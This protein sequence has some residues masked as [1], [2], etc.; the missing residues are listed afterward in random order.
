MIMKRKKC[1]I[2]Y[3]GQE[4]GGAINRLVSIDVTD[5]NIKCIFL[6]SDLLA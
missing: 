5:I 6:E 2:V 3:S 4:G 1:A